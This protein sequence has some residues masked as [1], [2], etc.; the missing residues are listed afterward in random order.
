M[1]SLF[2]LKR[3]LRRRSSRP[4]FVIESQNCTPATADFHP[5]QA[6]ADT[7]RDD[8]A[9]RSVVCRSDAVKAPMGP[10]KGPVTRGSEN[11]GRAMTLGPASCALC[12]VAGCG[13]RERNG[14][15]TSLLHPLAQDGL[16]GC[17]TKAA[18]RILKAW[19]L[20][21]TRPEN[22]GSSSSL[23]VIS[24]TDPPQGVAVGMLRAGR[25]RVP[26]GNPALRGKARQMI[27]RV[28]ADPRRHPAAA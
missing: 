10:G 21:K 9:L 11:G 14:H 16:G 23:S 24:S 28:P 22:G 27:E 17:R 25:T 20:D 4:Q 15:R 7:M 3:H 6:K 1:S 19:V 13:Y 5:T 26:R 2:S 18:P 12:G 8:T